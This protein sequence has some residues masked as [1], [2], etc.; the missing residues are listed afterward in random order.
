MVETEP[1]MEDEADLEARVF[2]DDPAAA[3]DQT[4]ISRI[5]TLSLIKSHPGPAK[6]N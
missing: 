1:V 6:G 5:H 2:R 3:T 4:H